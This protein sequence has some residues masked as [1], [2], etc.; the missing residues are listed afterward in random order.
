MSRLYSRVNT[1]GCTDPSLAVQFSLLR[2]PRLE[3]KQALDGN[4]G[5]QELWQLLTLTDASVACPSTGTIR[6]QA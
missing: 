5:L 3:N 1:D 2:T 6:L 4:W